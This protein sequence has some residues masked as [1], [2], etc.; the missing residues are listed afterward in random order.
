MGKANWTQDENGTWLPNPAPPGLDV[1]LGSKWAAAAGCAVLV[2]ACAGL[3]LATYGASGPEP[4]HRPA[5][6][7]WA[8]WSVLAWLFVAGMVGVACY[9]AARLWL[10]VQ[11]HRAGVSRAKLDSTLVQPAANGL[12]PLRVVGGRMVNPNA[13]PAGIVEADGDMP[14]PASQ[15]HREAAARAS[16]VQIAAGGG[17]AGAAA[18]AALG[19]AH[20]PR[21]LPAVQVIDGEQLT[22]V[23]RLLLLE[24]GEE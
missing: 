13:A 8:G 17:R 21:E 22:H 1:G 11:A 2:L 12:Y 7:P 4:A 14:A 24:A 15:D 6:E 16:F 23:E 19:G 3:S 20:G 18:V 5:P 10:S 9:L